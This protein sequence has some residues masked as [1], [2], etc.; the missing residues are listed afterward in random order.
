[1]K[2]IKQGLPKEVVMSIARIS[3]TN[4]R[5]KKFIRSRKTHKRKP[6]S[7]RP[8]K[9]TKSH[10]LRLWR[11]FQEKSFLSTRELDDRPDGDVDHMTVYR[12]LIEAG[13]VEK[14]PTSHFT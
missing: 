2:L 4:Y 5:H 9:L 8:N 10:K 11:N 6:G 1:M 3:Q 12:Y 13:F 14:K 7:E